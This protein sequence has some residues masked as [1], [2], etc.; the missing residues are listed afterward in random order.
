MPMNASPDTRISEPSVHP[1]RLA[2]RQWMLVLPLMLGGCA[3]G[4][5]DSEPTPSV[6][7]PERLEEL[8]WERVEEDR[9]RFAQGDVHFMRQMIPHHAQALAMVRMAEST[10]DTPALLRLAGRIG[11]SQ[12]DEIRLMEDWMRARGQEP[13]AWDLEGSRLIR[14]DHEGGMHESMPGMLTGGQ[15]T[16]LREARGRTF[17]RLFLEY[18]IE[19]HQGAVTM[20]RELFATDGAAQDPHVFRL[21]SDVQVDQT[22]EIARMQQMLAALDR[23]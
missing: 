1:G 5:V 2:C 19:H 8:Y 10:S 11:N 21:A 17:D 4:E 23:P 6:A 3:F 12:R 14:P 22:T 16:E 15:M 7:E 9:A 18:M 13:P 20:V